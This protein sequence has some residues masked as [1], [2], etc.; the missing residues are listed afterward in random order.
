MNQDPFGDRVPVWESIPEPESKPIA[1]GFGDLHLSDRPP[2]AR[3]DEPDWYAAMAWPIYQLKQIA[4][5]FQVPVICSGDAMDR[6]SQPPKLVN[7]AIQHLPTMHCVSGNHDQPWH[8]LEQIQQSSYWTLVEAKKIV[9]LPPGMP[10][11]IGNLVLHGFPHGCDVTPLKKED[12]FFHLAVVH[13]FIWTSRTGHEGASEDSRLGVWRARLV[14]YDAVLMGDNHLTLCSQKQRPAILNPGAFLRRTVAE[15]D[16]E[17][18]V[19]LLLESGR[20]V[21]VNLDTTGE[22]LTEITHASK[23]VD[24]TALVAELANLSD[25]VADFQDAVEGFFRDHLDT[26]LAVKTLML[27]ALDK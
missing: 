8:S 17:P 7:W 21:R 19:G 16:H 18:C 15:R 10:K 26:N 11:R 12:D 13:A 9:D 2:L 27:K 4:K 24:I 1:V 6:W 23:S 25:K 5:R 14:G 22:K 20:W 3:S